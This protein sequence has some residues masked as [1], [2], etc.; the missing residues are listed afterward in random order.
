MP[1]IPGATMGQVKRALVDSRGRR[2]DQ[3]VVLSD[4]ESGRPLRNIFGRGQLIDQRSNGTD[5]SQTSRIRAVLRGGAAS[6]RLVYANWYLPSG[7]SEQPMGNS[8]DVKASIENPAINGGRPNGDIVIPVFFGGKRTATVENNSMVISD[9]VLVNADADW[10]VFVRSM[11]SVASGGRFPTNYATNTSGVVQN[12]LSGVAEGFVTN[13]DSVDS[14][15][16]AAATGYVFGPVAILAEAVNDV[17]TH[18]AIVLGDSIARGTGIVTP[19]GSFLAQAA[20]NAGLPLMRLAVGGESF[21]YAKSAVNAYRRMALTRYARH[22]L[23]NMGINDIRTGSSLSTLK[24]DA[25]AFWKMIA[26]QGLK[27]HQATILPS[28]GASTDGYTTAAGQSI[29]N[30]AWEAVRT[31]FNS[32]LRS[33]QA[34]T[35]SGGALSS[36]IDAAAVIEVNSAGA[37]TLNGGF[38]KPGTV[39]LTGTATGITS[40]TL[41]DTSKSRTTNQ[42][43]NLVVLITSATTGAGQLARVTSNTASTWSLNPAFSPTPTGTVQYQIASS[44]TYD[45]LH[46]TELV[47]AEIAAALDLGYLLA[48]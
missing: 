12:D 6:I 36:V 10:A 8:Y 20:I 15:T 17:H 48:A 34:K 5:T 37:L 39:V 9:P 4:F 24:A 32:W 18:G 25:I 46:P 45:H 23:V 3:R 35:D 27:V 28:P 11:A 30:T 42:D 33:G 14:G 26:A 31:G 19:R 7:S 2:L 16:I 38:W 40:S 47:H 43:Q 44:P 29:V 1:Q 21:A 22:A 41:S 13:T